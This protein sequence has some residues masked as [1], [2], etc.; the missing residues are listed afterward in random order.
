MAIARRILATGMLMACQAESPAAPF[1]LSVE[2][3]VEL[4]PVAQ[5]IRT[6]A[7]SEPVC[8]LTP[9]IAGPQWVAHDL[10]RP[11]G[12]VL[13]PPALQSTSAPTGEKTFFAPDLRVGVFVEEAKGVASVELLQDSPWPTGEIVTCQLA[14]GTLESLVYL[15]SQAHPIHAGDSVHLAFLQMAGPGAEVVRAGAFATTRALRDSLVG[16]LLAIPPAAPEP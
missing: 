6:E 7:R 14:L 15:I 11:S 12:R 4:G 13:L 3:R 2:E 16:A 9:A 5:A 8:P 10:I 1:G